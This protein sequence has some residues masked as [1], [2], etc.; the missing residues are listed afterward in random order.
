KFKRIISLKASPIA[1]TPEG[2]TEIR[3]EVFNLDKIWREPDDNYSVKM[4]ACVESL[5]GA[6]DNKILT[7]D[8]QAPTSQFNPNEKLP[9]TFTKPAETAADGSAKKGPPSSPDCFGEKELYEKIQANSA[10]KC[11]ICPF[12]FQC[13]ESLG[14]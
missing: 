7:M 14:L 12:E 6:L 3:A 8:T 11:T 5:K 4:A 13:K 2:I 1:A 10:Q 9:D